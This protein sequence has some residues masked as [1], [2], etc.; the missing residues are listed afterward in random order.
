MAMSF[1]ASQQVRNLISEVS[2]I[3][4]SHIANAD[5]LIVTLGMDSVELIDLFMRLETVGIIV[6]EERITA[7]LTVGDIAALSVRA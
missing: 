6:P 2:G 3:P 1:T 5:S 7:E 4:V